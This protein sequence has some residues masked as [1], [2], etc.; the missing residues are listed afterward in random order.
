MVRHA[1][2]AG[3]D[4]IAMSPPAPE[5]T[6]TH[7]RG[8]KEPQLRHWSALLAFVAAMLLAIAGG[9]S[10]AQTAVCDPCP[11]DCPMMLPDGAA[12]AADHDSTAPA[13]KSKAP[14]Q[15]TVLCQAAPVVAPIPAGAAFTPLSPTRATMAWTNAPEAPSRPPDRNLR[16]PISA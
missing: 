15:Q 7:F 4:V 3:I 11:P 10:V 14:C 6:Q 9:P 16:P 12:A 2:A 1:R 5:T 13:Q 8:R